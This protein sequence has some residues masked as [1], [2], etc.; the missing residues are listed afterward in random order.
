MKM[1]TFKYHF[2][3]FIA[4]LCAATLFSIEKNSTKSIKDSII[5]DNKG[6]QYSFK[7]LFNS[8]SLLS[9]CVVE[10]KDQNKKLIWKKVFSS[11]KE[12]YECSDATMSNGFYLVG[13]RAKYIPGGKISAGWISNISPAGKVLS[14][15]IFFIS[16]D[17]FIR[18]ILD[19][20]SSNAVLFIA[21]LKKNIPSTTIALIDK[22]TLQI[23]L[24]KTFENMYINNIK[25]TVKKDRI[26]IDD[27]YK[28]E[29]FEFLFQDNSG[30][31]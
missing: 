27:N 16:N 19:L 7:R 9:T 3:I 20:N 25:Y 15:N 29:S 23:E 1:K 30:G 12:S 17:T 5:F 18:Q 14:E 24:K 28:K 31:E 2:S 8:D 21:S 26:N 13:A 10:K 6:Y 22:N 11:D 4:L